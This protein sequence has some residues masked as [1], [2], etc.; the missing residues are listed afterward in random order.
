[1]QKYSSKPSIAIVIVL[2]VLALVAAWP[3]DGQVSASG[4]FALTWPSRTPTPTQSAGEPTATAASY[5]TPTAALSSPTSQPSAT[6][7]PPGAA[8]EQAP[9][10]TPESDATI[11]RAAGGVETTSQ[12][13]ATSDFGTIRPTYAAEPT[14]LPFTPAGDA[15]KDLDPCGYPFALALGSANSRSGPGTEYDVTNALSYLEILPV[16]GRAIDSPWWRVLFPDGSIGWV[17]DSAVRIA[18]DIRLVSAYDTD[19]NRDGLWTPEATSNCSTIVM[20]PTAISVVESVDAPG[21]AISGQDVSLLPPAASTPTEPATAESNGA[22]PF[23]KSVTAM[24]L[25]C[26]GLLMITVALVL[27]V[28]RGRRDRDDLPAST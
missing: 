2:I 20:Q 14:A 10:I 11:T 21:S 25:P 9:S 18:G 28:R 13:P 3:E 19:L 15:F 5:P 12:P 17:S 26:A 7:S 16:T 8:T 23:W 1:M 4:S 22:A 24:A 6:P 27:L